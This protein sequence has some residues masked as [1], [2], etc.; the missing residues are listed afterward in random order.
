MLLPV[1]LVPLVTQVML[2]NLI[3]HVLLAPP[4]VLTV[5]P[6][7]NV[8]LVVPDISLDSHPPL[9]MV[10]LPPV[11]MLVFLVVILALTLLLV[12]F[13]VLVSI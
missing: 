1:P 9:L 3:N 13:V 8:P 7:L 5:P 6:L 4:V 2:Y 12:P 11:V 10:L